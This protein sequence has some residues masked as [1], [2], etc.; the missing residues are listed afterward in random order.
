MSVVKMIENEINIERRI[1]QKYETA[2]L[3]EDRLTYRIIKG[4]PRFFIRGRKE[5]KQK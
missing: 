3:S 5:K 4:I 1:L 2:E